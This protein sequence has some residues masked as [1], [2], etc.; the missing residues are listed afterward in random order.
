MW[1]FVGE[2]QRSDDETST[3]NVT[4]HLLATTASISI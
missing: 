3:L 2:T 4:D 1:G